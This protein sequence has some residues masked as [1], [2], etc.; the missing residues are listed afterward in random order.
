MTL[1]LREPVKKCHGVQ[2]VKALDADKSRSLVKWRYLKS[3]ALP[4]Y[5]GLCARI[6]CCAPAVWW[7]R[8][9][10]RE[11]RPGRSHTDSKI[12]L[13][14]VHLPLFFCVYSNT[15]KSEVFFLA[16]RW[17]KHH[18]YERAHALPLK[19]WGP[20]W[21]DLLGTVSGPY[22]C[23]NCVGTIQKSTGCQRTRLMQE[24]QSINND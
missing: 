23:L 1:S 9:M 22:A 15:E 14:A 2:Q 13:Y 5:W 4:F 20:C 16:Q 19:A 18:W 8:V 3:L 10:K 24:N 21:C 6:W 12:R 17:W 11:R 7:K